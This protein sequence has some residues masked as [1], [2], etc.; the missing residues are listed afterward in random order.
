MSVVIVVCYKGWMD[1][2]QV[3]DARLSGGSL[4]KKKNYFKDMNRKMRRIEP[5]PDRT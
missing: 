1:C 3:S 5:D 2:S 4:N